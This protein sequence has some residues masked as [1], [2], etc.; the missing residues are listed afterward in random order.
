MKA[1]KAL[2]PLHFNPVLKIFFTE[3]DV[4][5]PWS[6]NKENWLYAPPDIRKGC[7]AVLEK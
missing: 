4:S 5:Y 1:Q 7:I 6:G 2:R 3:S